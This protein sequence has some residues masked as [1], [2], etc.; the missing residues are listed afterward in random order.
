[1][2]G[3]GKGVVKGKRVR[4]EVEEEKNRRLSQGNSHCCVFYQDNVT[5][6]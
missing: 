3:R 2:G 4:V 5:H 6:E 1:M